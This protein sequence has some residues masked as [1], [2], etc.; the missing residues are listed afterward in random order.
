MAYHLAPIE[1]SGKVIAPAEINTLNNV[2]FVKERHVMEMMW[3]IRKGDHCAMF[4]P[5][6]KSANGC[7]AANDSS[8][9]SDSHTSCCVR[10]H[11]M[12]HHDLNI[13]E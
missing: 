11:K 10:E 12:I 5:L 13:E 7:E 9:K 2:M 8:R 6:P 1:D 3:K 4:S